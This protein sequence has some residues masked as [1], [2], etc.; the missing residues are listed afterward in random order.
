MTAWRAWEGYWFRP[1]PL[2]NLAFV[3]LIAVGFQLYHLT[4]IQPR[5]VFGQLAALPDLLYQP[6]VVMRAFTWPF[7]PH[8]RPSGD[9]VVDVYWLTFAVGMFAFIG[10][11]TTLTLLLFTAGNVFLQ[12]FEY[13]FTEVHHSEAI[14]MITLAVL[15]LSPAGDALS[16][17]D[18]LRRLRAV[19]AGRMVPP[20][21]QSRES[22][23]A[24]WPLLLV[25]W[26]FALIYLSAA[27][28]KL[29]A[30]GLDWMNGWTLQYYMLQDALRWGSN[31]SGVGSPYGLEPGAG[32]WIGQY[33]T[34]ATLASWGSILFESTF[35]IVLVIPQ[36]TPV[37]LLV[38][39][40]FHVGIY[41]IQRAPFLSFVWLYA[42]FVPWKDLFDRVGARAAGRIRQRT[43]HYDPASP[44]SV[45]RAVLI[46]YFD[47]FGVV[48]VAP[49]SLSGE[50]IDAARLSR[51][52]R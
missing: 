32:V 47:W 15:A 40:A 27:F 37:Y 36:L 29:S 48:V 21:R 35:W 3:R 45:K 2:F 12:A 16:A 26:T 8:Y 31:V 51:S 24:R 18:V 50:A 33:H 28:H 49:N 34:I 42:V 52:A 39:A 46:Q 25:Q 14:V 11:R 19:D 4:M 10:Y 41:Y 23:F 9:L 44:R 5:A 7:G 20:D 1:A 13:S 6:L 38:G 30:S 22:P 43:L 17:D